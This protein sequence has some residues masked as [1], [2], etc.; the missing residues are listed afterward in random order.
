MHCTRGDL[1]D[2][3]GCISPIWAGERF[4]VNGPRFQ[5]EK[6]C[7]EANRSAPLI[8]DI[9]D[10]NSLRTGNHGILLLFKANSSAPPLPPPPPLHHSYCTVRTP[11]MGHIFQMSNCHSMV[12]IREIN[13]FAIDRKSDLLSFTLWVGFFLKL[14]PALIFVFKSY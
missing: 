6:N 8:I 10:R 3:F 5:Y 12:N 2:S 13:L 1:P 9:M 11:V 4:S 14:M 7:K